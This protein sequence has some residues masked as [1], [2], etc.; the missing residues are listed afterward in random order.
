MMSPSMFPH[1][2]RVQRRTV[3]GEDR[4]GNDTYDWSVIDQPEHARRDQAVPTDVRALCE[5]T[6]P[7]EVTVGADVQQSEWDITAQAGVNLNGRDR[8]VILDIGDTPIVCKVIG[9]PERPR[10]GRDEQYVRANASSSDVGQEA[11]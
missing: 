8:I 2:I 4:F 1:T 6:T 11:A 3:S 9:P 10:R 7:R 5:R